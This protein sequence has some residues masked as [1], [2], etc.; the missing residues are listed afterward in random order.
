MHG[1]K[2]GLAGFGLFLVFLFL[3]FAFQPQVAP[4]NGAELLF[5]VRMENLHQK[6]VHVVGQ[7]QD[8]VPVVAHRFRLRQHMELFDAFA[9]G[10]I[11]VFLPFRHR[12]AIFLQRAE[13]RV[14]RA[15][16]EQQVLEQLALA[17]EG[18][19]QRVFKLQAE[20]L[21][22]QLVLFAVLFEHIG[23]LFFDF[24]FER[25][26]NDLEL[27]VLLEHFARDVQRQVLGIDDAL[28][29][30]EAVGQQFGAL[31]HDFHAARIQRQT[32][33]I[34]LGIIVVIRLFGD[35][36]Q[37]LVARRAL[38]LLVDDAQGLV[39]GVEALLVKLFVIRL[40]NLAF[41]L[42][43]KR[44]HAVDGL[45]LGVGLVL[46]LAALF[47]A[48]MLERHADGV[49]DIVGIFFD[50]RFYAVAFQK[51]VVIR[52]RRAFAD[53]QNDVRTRRAA[54][55][56]GNRIAVRARRLPAVRLRLAVGARNDLD[57]VGDHERR[58]KAHAELPDDVHV[59]FCGLVFLRKL[60]R[61]A[62]RNGAEVLVE[63]LLG[64]ADAVVGHR[65]QTLFFVNGQVDAEVV[66]AERHAVVRQRAKIQLV[67]GV[68]RIGDKLAQEN[69]PVRVNGMNHEV[70]HPLGL[71]LELLF[72]HVA[73]PPIVLALNAFEC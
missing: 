1:F 24:L 17:A 53:V 50:K 69:F 63:L 44:N 28:D 3:R 54:F 29:E 7:K 30:T 47:F 34:G 16:K 14:G 58:I 23:K 11:D 41:R 12:A 65:K 6:F 71:G 43:P 60:P 64:H 67:Y 18:R 48:R 68:A 35:E 52:L 59:A 36:Q 31:V 61:T 55:G 8:V 38:R 27:V 42:F 72:C 9:R 32:L 33:F 45:D 10:V 4:G 5:A 22:E 25:P 70:Q 73:K 37:R 62:F 2:Q 26:G 39:V 57:A 20:R 19:I 13:L 46:V 40:G 21:P 66:A 49:A 15:R 56:V 51:F